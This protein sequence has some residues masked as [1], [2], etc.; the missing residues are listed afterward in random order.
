MF[1]SNM[2]K[3]VL[4]FSLVFFVCGCCYFKFRLLNAMFETNK[5]EKTYIF[6]RIS[7][8]FFSLLLSFPF[9]HV[10]NFIHL[11]FLETLSINNVAHRIVS[12]DLY[13]YMYSFEWHYL[14]HCEIVVNIFFHFIFIICSILWESF[15]FCNT[16]W[17][18]DRVKNRNKI[19]MRP[20]NVLH[21]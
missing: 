18:F 8:H 9:F 21:W 10:A 17:Q 2:Y 13:V 7:F 6:C 20:E 3:S 19:K 16:V 1:R 12:F 5:N 15:T 14:A 11:H 4:R